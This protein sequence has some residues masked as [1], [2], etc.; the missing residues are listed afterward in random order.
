M[1]EEVEGSLVDHKFLLQNTWIAHLTFTEHQC[2]SKLQPTHSKSVAGSSQVY[3][4]DNVTDFALVCVCDWRGKSP[5][6]CV[7]SIT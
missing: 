6:V 4:I 2:N 3:S 1:N 5:Y 7:Y